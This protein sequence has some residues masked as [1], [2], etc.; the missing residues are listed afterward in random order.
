MLKLHS[1]TG[2]LRVS[3]GYPL[4]THSLPR[5]EQ[6]HLSLK[7]PQSQTRQHCF[8]EAFDMLIHSCL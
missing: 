3:L 4:L 2:V 1:P 6:K 8:K 7:L 5:P